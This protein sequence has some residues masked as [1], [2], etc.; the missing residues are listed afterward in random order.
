MLRRVDK[1]DPMPVILQKPTTTRHRLQ[2]TSLAFLAQVLVD[3]AALG[4]Q[5]HQGFR[6]V[7]VETVYDEDPDTA[8]IRVDR[9]GDMPSEVRLFACRSYRGRDHATGGYFQIGKQALRAVPDV[10]EFTALYQT[11]TRRFGRMLALCG[12]DARF[13]IGR[14][15][16]RARLMQGAGLAVEGAD[17]PG[18]FGKLRRVFNLWIEPVA[19]QVGF[20]LGFFL[21][22]APPCGAKSCQQCHA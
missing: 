14:D 19:A 15:Q 18:F 7:R 17:R 2:D 22:S 12:L 5:A 1:P 11:G 4:H 16:V 10:L 21:K 6:L 3:I 13:F 8:R 9:L 20:D